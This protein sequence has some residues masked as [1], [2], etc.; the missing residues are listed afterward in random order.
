VAGGVEGRA[1]PDQVLQK[2]RESLASMRAG[3]PPAS[4][5][6]PPEGVG[7]SGDGRVKATADFRGRI[8]A[9][10]LDP[11]AMRLGPQELAEHVITAVNGAFADLRAKANV[12]DAAEG[13]PDPAAL[14]KQVRDIQDQ[15]LRQMELIAQAISDATTKLRGGAR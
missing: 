9:V 7:E 10:E 3:R 12:A 13:I 8:K 5:E 4:D 2:A 6:P 11:R 14:A 1:D 15:G